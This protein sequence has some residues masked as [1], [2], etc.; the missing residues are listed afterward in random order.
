MDS[1]R[2]ACPT[3]NLRRR[4]SE[5]GFANLKFILLR[6]GALFFERGVL[7]YLR[8]DCQLSRRGIVSFEMSLEY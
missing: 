2:I 5:E 6:A 1:A 3:S 4:P 7:K 8:R